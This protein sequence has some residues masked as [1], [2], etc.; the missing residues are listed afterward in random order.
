MVLDNFNSS[1]IDFIDGMCIMTLATTVMTT[2]GSIFQPLGA[3][4]FVSDLY[5]LIFTS[6]A[7]CE[8]L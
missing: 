8:N 2:K 4:L 6:C 7:S 3:I 5:M 1:S